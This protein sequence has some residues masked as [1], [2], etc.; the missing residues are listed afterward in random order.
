ML[1]LC[2]LHCALQQPGGGTVESRGRG[3]QHGYPTSHAPFNEFFHHVCDL[4]ARRGEDCGCEGGVQLAPWRELHEYTLMYED[5][6]TQASDLVS[7]GPASDGTGLDS[8]LRDVKWLVVDVCCGIGNHLL[9]GVRGLMLALRMRRAIVF[10]EEGHLHYNMSSVIPILPPSVPSA[11]GWPQ[12][13]TK[14]VAT[15]HRDGH[16]GVRFLTCG[17]WDSLEHYQFVQLQGLTDV[18]ISYLHPTEGAWLREHVGSKPFFYLSHFL[19]TGLRATE[20]EF[21]VQTMSWPATARYSGEALT[22]SQ[23]IER[24]RADA[25]GRADDA[26]EGARA[27]IVGVQ[28][29]VGKPLTGD[30]D[31]NLVLFPH[32]DIL[33]EEWDGTGDSPAVRYCNGDRAALKQVLPCVQV[34]MCAFPSA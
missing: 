19:W 4:C 6:V 24:I 20:R 32:R 23:L 10:L 34:C 27:A 12:R 30:D 8:P 5:W 7:A 21:P 17:D 28:L 31:N 2:L 1:L 9:M 11:L 16:L 18:H 26:E 29:R 22:L 3:P 14:V 25:D 15:D 33:A 13:S